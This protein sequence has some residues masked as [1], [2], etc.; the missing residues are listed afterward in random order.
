MNPTAADTAASAADIG[1]GATGMA[2]MGK[3]ALVLFAM[4][5]FILLC[6][7]LL[8]KI[9]LERAPGNGNPALKVI[10]SK[11]VGTK[12]RVVVVELEDTWLVLGV[13]AG[14]IDK[15][16]ERPAPPPRD[17]GAGTPAPV[18][19]ESRF[20]ERFARALQQN[21]RLPGQNP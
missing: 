13:G 21:F 9:G 15:L 12:E 14:R 3:T 8:K 7:W 4:V 11:A 5:A 19:G 2:A 1:A 10:A 17:D 6:A 20:S 18:D 16:H